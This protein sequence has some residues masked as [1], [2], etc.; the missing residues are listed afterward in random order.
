M[1]RPISGISINR[2]FI[3]SLVM[4]VILAA[5]DYHLF[6][7]R[8]AKVE[9]YDDLN[10]RLSSI[11]VSITKLEYLLDMFVVARRFEGTTVDLIKSDVED[12]DESI[13]YIL[14]NTGYA[15]VAASDDLLSEGLVSIAD[16]WELIKEEISRLNTAT[17]Q[18]EVMLIHNAVDLHTII[19]TEK[20]ERF[21]GFINDRRTEVFGEF[22][23]LVRGSIG[24]F[25]VIF[26]IFSLLLQKTIVTPLRRVVESAR[27]V[28]SGWPG[29]RFTE[30]GGGVAAETAREL[31]H[32]LNDIGREFAAREKER[33]TLAE[34]MADRHTQMEVLKAVAAVASRSISVDEIF[35]GA[36]REGV[37]AAGGDGGCVFLAQ[38]DGGALR[39]KASHGFD[40][41]F[42]KEF[43]KIEVDLLGIRGVV[44]KRGHQSLA[45]AAPEDFPGGAFWDH[46]REKG[47]RAAACAPV[48]YDNRT[49]GYLF[50]AYRDPDRFSGDV[51]VFIESLASALGTLNG[52]VGL[53]HG[54]HSEKKFFERIIQQMPFGVAVFTLEGSC[55]VANNHVRRSLG[56]PPGFDLVGGYNVFADEVFSSGG[57]VTSLQKTYEGYTT[58]FIIK[59][60][61]G[62]AGEKYSF[63]GPARKLK[64][65]SFPLYDSGG[66]IGEI[67]LL[68][69]VL[70]EVDEKGSGRSETV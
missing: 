14:S 52:Y 26:L 11:R 22:K 34:R 44:Q 10:N 56:A 23:A 70:E 5:A 32:M 48:E 54:E 16:D 69:D 43:E 63:S 46:L 60:D 21:I 55:R 6:S 25:L 67:A 20:A 50:F 28:G 33:N 41:K 68:Y 49:T 57:V 38:G 58:E 18:D 4:L 64:V 31:N 53:F 36:V 47:F 37:H 62:K 17:T 1:K 19:I 29:L 7:V 66:E 12:L 42:S 13:G 30:S 15:S 24:G 27:R 3:V 8:S 2:K 65:R 61:P 9:L 45:Y 39:L 51:R 59:Y 35:S 40:D